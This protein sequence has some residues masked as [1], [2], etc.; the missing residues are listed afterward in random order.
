MALIKNTKSQIGIDG[1]YWRIVA[2][3]THYGG[4]NQLWPSK[5]AQPVTFVHVALYTDKKAR[6]AGA[7]SLEMKRIVLDGQSNGLAPDDPQ[8][9]KN[10]DHLPEPTRAAAYAALKGVRDFT[11]A[12]DD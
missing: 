10:P 12:S 9:H 4:P 1:N 11:G 7:M 8:F 6:D 2:I 5:H 3:E